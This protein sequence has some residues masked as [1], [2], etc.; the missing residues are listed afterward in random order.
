MAEETKVITVVAYSYDDDEDSLVLE[1]DAESGELV[2]EGA[3]DF[4]TAFMSDIDGIKNGSVTICGEGVVGYDAA[5]D[6]FTVDGRTGL[7]AESL[8]S[9]LDMIYN[10]EL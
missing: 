7:D 1:L 9:E 5:T 8:I 2:I 6:T 4:V 10:T 3:A